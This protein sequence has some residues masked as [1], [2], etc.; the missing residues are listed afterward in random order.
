[1]NTVRI[2]VIGMGNMG[3]Y[4]CNY[5]DTV[6]NAKLVAICEAD[7]AKLDTAAAKV[8]SANKFPRYQDLLT[9]KEIDAVLIATPHYQH[10]EITLAAFENNLHV[11]CE[12]PA[13]VT[14]KQART[15]NDA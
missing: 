7:P 4:H 12:K 6:E 5:M 11:H 9:S 14:V 3:T 13:A 2:G 1:M 10:P 15:M 8:P